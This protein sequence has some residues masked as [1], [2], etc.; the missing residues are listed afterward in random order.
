[1]GCSSSSFGR[2]ISGKLRVD[3]PIPDLSHQDSRGVQRLK[4][5]LLREL[6]RD[7]WALADDERR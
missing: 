2:L 4:D 1:M 3:Q 6:P 5:E 7:L